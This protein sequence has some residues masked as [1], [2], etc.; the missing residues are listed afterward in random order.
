MGQIYQ[1]ATTDSPCLRAMK[2]I[3]GLYRKLRLLSHTR[4]GCYHHHQVCMRKETQTDS[5]AL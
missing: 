2:C 4:G 5:L 3:R 1:R